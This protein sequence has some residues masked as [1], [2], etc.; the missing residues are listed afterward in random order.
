MIVIMV[1]LP[2]LNCGRASYNCILYIIVLN[3]VVFSFCF[4]IFVNSHVSVMN[5][6]FDSLYIC[7]CLNIYL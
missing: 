2:Q 5:L 3:L 1:A 6:V 4:P 7:V